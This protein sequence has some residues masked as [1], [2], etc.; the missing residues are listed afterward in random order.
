MINY[1][2]VYEKHIDCDFCG[3]MTRGRIWENEPG[4]IKCGACHAVI[5]FE[6]G[7]K[8]EKSADN[9]WSSR[10]R[11]NHNSPANSRRRT[12]TWNTP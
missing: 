9:S 2:Q 7:N 6:K 1:Q 4:V 3:A 5:D 12:Q 10:N 8:I 11:K